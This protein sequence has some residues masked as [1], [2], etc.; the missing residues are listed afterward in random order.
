MNMFTPLASRVNPSDAYGVLVRVEYTL[1]R[2]FKWM[3]SPNIARGWCP[4]TTHLGLSPASSSSV[5]CQ[6]HAYRWTAPH[7]L[8]TKSK[9]TGP[10][11]ERSGQSSKMIGAAEAT[12]AG[13][14][15]CMTTVVAAMTETEVVAAITGTVGMTTEEAMTAGAEATGAEDMMVRI[16]LAVGTCC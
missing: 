3:L 5:Y 14:G 8:A 4:A 11:S 6:L 10:T 1:Y 16:G 13:V 15:A 9:W 12:A 7:S 2:R